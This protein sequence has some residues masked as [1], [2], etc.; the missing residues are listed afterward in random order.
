MKRALTFA[1]AAAL[2]LSLAACGAPRRGRV[3]AAAL[4]AE[5]TGLAEALPEMES[6]AS[7]SSGAEAAR[8]F[9]YL[10]DMDYGLVE[11]YYMAYAAGGSAEE[12]AVIAVKDPGDLGEARASLERHLDGRRGL[13][14]VYDP[15]GAALLDSARVASAGSAAAL[16]VCENARELEAAFLEA[17]GG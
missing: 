9:P 8:L 4:G 12:I 1:L 6:V 7:G 5:L 2:A 15:A 17:A 16:L 10:S 11:G 14:A 3:D 13:F